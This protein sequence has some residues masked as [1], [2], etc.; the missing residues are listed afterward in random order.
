MNR[1]FSKEALQYYLIRVG[2]YPF[3]IMPYSWIHAIGKGLGMSAFYCMR[4][5]RKRALS[6]LALAT[7]LA[8]TKEQLITIAKKSFQNLAINCLE[9][10]RLAR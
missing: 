4:E 6:N 2:T 10:P 9:Y 1:R 8:L 7:D 3:S 5:Y